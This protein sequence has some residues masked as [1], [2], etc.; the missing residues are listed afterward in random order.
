[1][2]KSIQQFLANGTKE[3][4]K[5]FS[6]YDD[7][8]TK[9]AEMVY[10]V[11]SVVTGF[12][13]SMIAENWEKLDRLL[14]SRRELREGWVIE[15]RDD[16]RTVITSLGA[17]TF[18]RTYF[19]NKKTGEYAYLLDELIGL[20]SHERITEDAKARVL[21]EAAYTS[22][23]KGGENV[24]ISGDVI[25]KE[26]VM[27]LLH[28]LQFPKVQAEEKEQAEVVYIDADEDHVS[29]QYLNTKGDIPGSR[30]NT[31][32]PKM[33]YVYDGVTAEGDR[34]IL[35]N[36]KYFGGGY[37][38]ESGTEELWKEVFEYIE[39]RYDQKV[40]QKIYVNG[41]GATW[42]RSGAAKHAKAR[43]VLDKFHMC[44]YIVGATSHLLDSKEEVRSEIYRCIYGK[45]RKQLCGVFE[46]ILSVTEKESK[47]KAVEKARDYILGNWKGIMAMVEGRKS[48]KHLGCRAEGH[49]S[50]IYADR[51][52]SRPLGWCR[53]GAD[54]MARLRI[55]KWNGGN[56]LELVRYQKQEL[57]KAV[58]AE[59]VEGLTFYEVLASERR[60]ETNPEHVYD[61]KMYSIPYEQVKKIAAIKNHIYGL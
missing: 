35:Q 22:Y 20:E 57:P 60:I 61:T 11:T 55:F 44:E 37:D 2:D 49:I 29:L 18:H 4:N 36:V 32:M 58:G 53:T 7:D 13:C 50:H 19:R 39:K 42:I 10:G 6:E 40:L 17:V 31:Y 21:E 52:S 56:T 45:H 16:P 46:K 5:V 26:A 54:K 25:S 30:Y 43:F 14:S 1:M 9:I 41:D 47:A 3:L 12:G 33:V 28:P 48:D 24:S 27:D 23:R 8:L 15:R 59:G 51:M 38:G 34:H